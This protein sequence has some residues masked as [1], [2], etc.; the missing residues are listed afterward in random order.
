MIPR[1]WPRPADASA[2]PNQLR[3]R[4]ASG[5]L[6]Q[7]PGWRYP[8]AIDT[9]SGT[10]RF[11]NFNQHWGEEAELRSFMQ[12]YAVEACRIEARKK[13]MTVTEQAL[14]DGSIRLNLSEGT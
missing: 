12:M 5:L 13:G 11:D 6:V 7:L 2:W 8:L 9:A 1:L 10:I 14:A 4:E 3:A